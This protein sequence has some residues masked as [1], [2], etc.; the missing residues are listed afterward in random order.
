MC[1]YIYLHQW[2]RLIGNSYK[3]RFF[4]NAKEHEHVIE[5]PLE[6]LRRSRARFAIL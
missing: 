2:K 6:V 5:M 4:F 1:I 3:K